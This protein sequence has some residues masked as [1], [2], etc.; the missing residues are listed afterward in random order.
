MKLNPGEVICDQCNGTGSPDNNIN[1]DIINSFH[2]EKCH[3]YGK[4]DWVEAVVGKKRY[5]WE[6]TEIISTPLTAKERRLKDLWTVEF[7]HEV[8]S[9]FSEALFN[10]IKTR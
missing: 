8:K 2:C 4:L 9:I 6:D 1:D 5:R 10:G 3:G 7:N